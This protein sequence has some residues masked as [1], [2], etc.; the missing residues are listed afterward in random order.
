MNFRISARDTAQLPVSLGYSMT[1][2]PWM[3]KGIFVPRRFVST[4]IEGFSA[5]RTPSS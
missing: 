2:C 5:W 4:V 1:R 3:L